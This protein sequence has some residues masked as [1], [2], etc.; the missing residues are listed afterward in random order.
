LAD[1]RGRPVA[2]ALT[3]G[4]V[5]DVVIMAI[6]LLGAVAQ[7]KRVLADKAYDAACADG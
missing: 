5:A 3:P 6:P 4:N 7:P 2:F 1:D